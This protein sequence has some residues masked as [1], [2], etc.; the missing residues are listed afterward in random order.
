MENSNTERWRE[1]AELASKEQD[2]TRL[3]ELIRELD[4]ALDQKTSTLDPSPH[5]PSE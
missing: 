5:K 2:P 4:L 3:T 1:I